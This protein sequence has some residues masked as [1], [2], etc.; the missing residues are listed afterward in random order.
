MRE[1]NQHEQ[2]FKILLSVNKLE[3]T[4]TETFGATGSVR[5]AVSE[6]ASERW[7][8]G[9]ETVVSGKVWHGVES[10]VIVRGYEGRG[11]DT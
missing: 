3:V 8:H 10:A 9:V 4:I 7:R 6:G 2:K 11:G 1:S 5:H